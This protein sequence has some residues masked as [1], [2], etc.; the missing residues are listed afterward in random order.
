MGIHQKLLFPQVPKNLMGKARTFIQVRHKRATP[1]VSLTP[2]RHCK[3]TRLLCGAKTRSSFRTMPT[4]LLNQFAI[5]DFGPITINGP[6]ARH[7]SHSS[8][9]KSLKITRSGFE[10]L[11]IRWNLL[12]S[13]DRRLQITV[14][15]GRYDYWCL[16]D[17]PFSDK[18]LLEDFVFSRG[19]SHVFI[20]TTI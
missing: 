9:S 1:N 17:P 15:P 14:P 7:T 18:M 4:I 10:A 3:I 16:V 5:V 2:N 19:L 13:P 12:V 20:S 6:V 11:L 8:S